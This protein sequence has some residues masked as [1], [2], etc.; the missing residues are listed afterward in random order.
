M[1]FTWTLKAIK[2]L[3][4]SLYNALIVNGVGPIYKN[5]WKGKI[6]NKVKVFLWLVENNVFL[7]KE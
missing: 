3:V 6:T 5:I 1:F 2:T 4:K 7:T